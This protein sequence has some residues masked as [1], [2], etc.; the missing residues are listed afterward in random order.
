M[1]GREKLEKRRLT[2]KMG[3]GGFVAA[4]LVVIFSCAYGNAAF[5]RE[6]Y[7]RG[8]A[9]VKARNIVRLVKINLV[10][11]Q[12]GATET[13][14]PRLAD[15][16]TSM[17]VGLPAGASVT[18]ELSIANDSAKYQVLSKIAEQTA[19]AGV[20]YEILG[21]TQYIGTAAGKTNTFQLKVTNTTSE[22]KDV[23]LMLD[24][25][26]SVD[27]V[28]APT[29]AASTTAWTYRAVTVSVKNAGTATSGVDH[30]EYQMSTVNGATT[31]TDT[32]VTTN[33]LSVS[34]NGTS[35][36]QYRTVSKYGTKSAWSGKATVKF[37]D[38][39]PT[40]TMLTNG[41]YTNNDARDFA[42]ATY[43][44]SG[45]AITCKDNYG[46]VATKVSTLHV[47][48]GVTVKCTA[49]SNAGKSSEEVSGVY[50]RNLSFTGGDSTIRC[51]DNT[52]SKD[53]PRSGGVMTLPYGY[54]QFGP[55]V[56]TEA[57][58]YYVQ[59]RGSNFNTANMRLS[60]YWSNIAGY[61]IRSLA[62]SSTNINYYIYVPSV[63][64][65]LE[66][67]LLNTANSNIAISLV[68]ITKVST[69]PAS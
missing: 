68:K 30:Y 50:T 23:T 63:A 54:T 25:T 31:T 44:P 13:Y 52:Y 18:Y 67:T 61:N 66:V 64:D 16:A 27:E 4:A 19:A 20:S 12:G 10:D 51:I 41:T 60:S 42:S 37:D 58:C 43:G 35:T 11:V 39:T 2:K 57:G 38:V 69:C 55:Y 40:V 59:Y 14:A 15:D 49:K 26:F 21:D 22:A 7:A 24:Y 28:V 5:S 1:L 56:K 29:I 8:T 45:G 9:T 65:Q 36:V 6:L 47:L 34:K 46:N 17:F 3:L 32:G 62:V 48:G 53:C 33:T